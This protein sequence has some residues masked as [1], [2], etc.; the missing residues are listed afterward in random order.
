MIGQIE[1]RKT[2]SLFYTTLPIFMG[3]QIYNS[4]LLIANALLERDEN[5]TR[6]YLYGQCYPLFK[7][8]FDR[9]ETDC[10]S[11]AEFINEIYLVI[12]TPGKKSGHCQLENYRGESTL[13]SWLKT[14]CLYYCYDKYKKKQRIEVVE[15]YAQNGDNIEASDRIL[16]KFGSIDFDF[17]SINRNDILKYI[18]MMPNKRYREIMRLR[19]VEDL[20]NEETAKEMGM[21]M[22]IFYNKHLSARKQYSAV[23]KKE[24]EKYE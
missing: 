2:T 12:L 22:D 4:D 21:S 14:T 19:Y 8:I 13:T 16:D 17:K 7:S 10:S 20:S 15:L 23:V 5:I 9:F 6:S 11:C 24:E 18:S 3:Q 1:S